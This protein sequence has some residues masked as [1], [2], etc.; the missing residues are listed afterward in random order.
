MT[1]FIRTILLGTSSA[2]ILIKQFF[3]AH[4]LGAE[5]FG[6]YSTVFLMVALFQQLG[7]FGTQAYYSSLLINLDDE[8]KHEKSL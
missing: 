3:I 4:N 8:V 5:L 2:A 1:Y 7:G 6:I